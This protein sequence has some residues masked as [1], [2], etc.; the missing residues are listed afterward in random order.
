MLRLAYEK[1][2]TN[3][4]GEEPVY[5]IYTY[6]YTYRLEPPDAHASALVSS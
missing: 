4:F 1:N 6:M 2:L 5:L 3:R